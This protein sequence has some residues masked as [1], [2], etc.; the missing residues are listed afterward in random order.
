MSNPATVTTDEASAALKAMEE[1][2][3]AMMIQ[4]PFYSTLAM[5]LELTPDYTCK[6]A[7]VD[8]K[9]LGF[10]P[11]YVLSLPPSERRGLIAHE[12]AHCAKLHFSRRGHRDHKEWNAACDLD[13]NPEL[14][15]AGFNL[16]AG[17]LNEA[18]FK[19]MAEEEIYNV[20]RKEKQDQQDKQQDGQKGQQD[21]QQQQGQG[22]GQQDKQPQQDGQ[23]QAAGGQPGKDKPQGQ[24][25]DGNGQNGTPDGQSA[26]GNGQG[27]A[28]DNPL[29]EIRDA[30][31]GHD[32]AETAEIEREWR[33]NVRQAVAVARASNAGKLPGHLESI[34]AATAAPRIDWKAE[35]RRFIDTSAQYDISWNR[36][37]RRFVARGMFLPGRVSDGLSHLVWVFDDSSSIDMQV[38]GESVAEAQAALD[39]GAIDRLTIVFC[40]VEVHRV[41]TFETGDVL[42]ITTRGNGGTKFSPAFQYI[43]DNI[44]DAS[45]IIYS[46]DLDC[47]DYGIE[48]SAP[49]IWAAY[50]TR[51]EIAERGAKVPFGEVLHVNA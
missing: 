10:N 21:G 8:G 49:L 36:P 20:R 29:G 26:P 37:N 32:Q 2:R 47:K 11:P 38:F 17:V 33:A 16:P 18:R 35:L 24:Q 34:N 25:Q 3:A 6:T 15:E 27:Q 5:Y 39:E 9:R 41:E 23:Q 46:T 31:P 22:N 42:K 1:A 48:P 51:K 43:A 45:A 44:S 14:I 7:W 19:G 30:A 50:G 28:F 4:E 40:N 12:T 13:I